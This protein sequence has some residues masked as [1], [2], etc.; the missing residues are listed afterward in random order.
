MVGIWIAGSI[1]T[2]DDVDDDDDDDVVGVISSSSANAKSAKV[3]N[4]EAIDDAVA[5]D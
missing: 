3:G 1:I 4:N 5:M 2:V